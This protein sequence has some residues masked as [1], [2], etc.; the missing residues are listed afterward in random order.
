[1]N[2]IIKKIRGFVLGLFT[3]TKKIAQIP[4]GEEYDNWLGV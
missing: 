4:Q 3:K 2:I 1:M